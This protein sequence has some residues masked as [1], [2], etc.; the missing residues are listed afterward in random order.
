MAFC[1]DSD[2]HRKLERT[3]QRS[4][5]IWLVLLKGLLFLFLFFAL[6]NIIKEREDNARPF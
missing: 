2:R 6:A 3:H 5:M 4:A 1:V